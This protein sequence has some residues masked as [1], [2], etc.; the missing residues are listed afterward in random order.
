M[1]GHSESTQHKCQGFIH[2]AQLNF[3]WVGFDVDLPIPFNIAYL[4]PSDVRLNVPV[5]EIPVLSPP[6]QVSI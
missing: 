6:P 2:N 1:P 3:D 4:I 5:I